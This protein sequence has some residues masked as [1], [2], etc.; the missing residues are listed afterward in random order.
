MT[1]EWIT[2]VIR[3]RN[4]NQRER[5]RGRAVKTTFM[6]PFE[7]NLLIGWSRLQFVFRVLLADTLCTK[8][9]LCMFRCLL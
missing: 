3:C 4:T 6:E 8:N 2:S 7:L 9:L 5:G 1:E